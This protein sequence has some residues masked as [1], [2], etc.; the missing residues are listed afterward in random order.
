[1]K[2]SIELEKQNLLMKTAQPITKSDDDLTS[3][4][5]VYQRDLLEQQI[6]QLQLQKQEFDAQQLQYQQLLELAKTELF[7]KG[8]E[9]HVINQIQQT[10]AALTRACVD[11]DALK[12]DFERSE[13][14]N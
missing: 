2:L 9:Q 1:V 5:V 4:R 8:I 7:Q 6:K 3:K 11:L 12:T 13:K 14:E 10:T